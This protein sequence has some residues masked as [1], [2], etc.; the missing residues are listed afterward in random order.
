MRGR[1]IGF[2]AE[3]TN[4]IPNYHQIFPLIKSSDA[5]YQFI[6]CC[7]YAIVLLPWKT[8]IVM[9]GDITTSDENS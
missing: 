8:A 1:N 5:Q 6:S 4:I 3:L 7:C 2:Y 9:S